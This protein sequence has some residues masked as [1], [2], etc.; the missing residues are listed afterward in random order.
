MNSTPQA[1]EIPWFNGHNI[2]SC[3][4]LSEWLAETY[5]EWSGMRDELAK[6]FDRGQDCGRD[7]D[8]QKDI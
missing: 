5:P 3:Y 1:R 6:F 8:T 7:N 4:L 2:V